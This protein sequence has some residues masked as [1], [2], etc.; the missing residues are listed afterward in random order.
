MKTP[1]LDQIALSSLLFLLS[2]Q[3]ASA[4][5]AMVWQWEAMASWGSRIFMSKA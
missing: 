4:G 3:H 1:W 2:M 5:P